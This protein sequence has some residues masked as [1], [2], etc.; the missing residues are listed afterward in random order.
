MARL[1]PWMVVSREDWTRVVEAY[2]LVD[3]PYPH[4]SA[5][6]VGDDELA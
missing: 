5:A 3:A 2:A 1:L 4:V 6:A